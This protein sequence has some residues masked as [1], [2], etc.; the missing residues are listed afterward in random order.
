MHSETN[1]ANLLIDDIC[2]ADESPAE[3]RAMAR[4]FTETMVIAEKICL[5]EK[6]PACLVVVEQNV[7][8]VPG[9]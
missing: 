7:G 4:I 9:N 3:K 8:Q 6:M 5:G 1:P 2:W